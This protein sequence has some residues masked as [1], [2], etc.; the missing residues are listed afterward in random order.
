MFDTSAVLTKPSYILA[1]N[2]PTRGNAIVPM[3]LNT[4][5]NVNNLDASHCC[6]AIVSKHY[7]Y[8]DFRA[9][10]SISGR[11]PGTNLIKL[12][13]SAIYECL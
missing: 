9:D 2:L 10:E 4:V 12:F 5:I 13:A 1:A 11:K 7:I 6:S 8:V 3:G